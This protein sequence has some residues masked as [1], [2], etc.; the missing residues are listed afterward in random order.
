MEKFYEHECDLY[1]LFIDFRQAFDSICREE[2][3]KALKEMKILGKLIRL[4]Q[5]IME[6][7]KARIRMGGIYI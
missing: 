3:Y 1:M 6:N 7:T 5:M 2:L 4:V